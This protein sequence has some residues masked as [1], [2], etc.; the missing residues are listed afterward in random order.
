MREQPFVGGKNFKSKKE[1]IEYTQ[2][3]IKN[4]GICIID[5]ND[6]DFIFFKELFLRR[7]YN[8]QF[9]NHI[10]SF[11]IST[12]TITKQINHMSYITT[13]DKEYNFSWKKCCEG[14]G[15]DSFKEQIDE[16]F[17]YSIKDQREECW[18]ENNKCYEC[19][20]PRIN[21]EF[22]I[23]HNNIDFC[24]IVKEFMEINKENKP[25]SFDKDPSTCQYKFKEEDNT[26]ME[27]F[28]KFHKEKSILKLLCKP[29]HNKKTYN[30]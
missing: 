15:D 9:A 14:K 21:R 5:T 29:C 13:Y 10:K 27:A 8:K 22:Q 23:D 30:L 3:L 2:K 4:K 7:L 6:K 28:Q 11:K 25:T 1:L 26:F 24:E 19:G 16:A 12:N 18:Y 17:R 20:L